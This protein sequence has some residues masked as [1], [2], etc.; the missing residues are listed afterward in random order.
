[1]I[2]PNIKVSRIPDTNDAEILFKGSNLN[3]IDLKTIA[4]FLKEK[5]AGLVRISS[6]FIRESIILVTLCPNFVFSGGFIELYQEFAVFGAN[7]WLQ[8]LGLEVTA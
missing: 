1:M 3:V 8:S 6:T 5:W 2:K 4:T 7:C